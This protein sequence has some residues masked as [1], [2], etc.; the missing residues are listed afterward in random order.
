M[1]SDVP[2]DPFRGRRVVA[3]GR[4]A[5]IPPAGVPLEDDVADE[6]EVLP[7]VDGDTLTGDD[8]REAAVAEAKR[9][10]VTVRSNMKTETIERKVAEAKAEG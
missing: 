10:G 2:H 1:R 4:F 3:R 5:A 9:L 8:R 6:D 7:A